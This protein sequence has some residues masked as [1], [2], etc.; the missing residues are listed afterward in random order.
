MVSQIGS[1]M[2][3]STKIP[4]LMTKIM[5]LKWRVSGKY[6]DAAIVITDIMTFSEVPMA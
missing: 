4:M 5:S 6:L 2:G 1:E 3:I